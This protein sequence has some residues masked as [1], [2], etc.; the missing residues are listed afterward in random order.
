MWTAGVPK[1]DVSS[2]SGE[3]WR[4]VEDQANIATMRV[5]D[6]LSEQELLER[7]I[8]ATKPALP[9]ACKNFHFLIATP[10]RYAPYP[11]GSRFRRASQADGVF[12]AS[13]LVGTAV[14]ESAF[15]RTLFIAEAPGMPLPQRSVSH[16]AFSVRITTDN[17]I[18][19]TAEPLVADASKWTHPTDYGACQD[20]ADEARRQDIG[21]IRYRSIRSPSAEG[22]NAAILTPAAF[23]DHA[24]R[25]LQT[26]HM[27]MR[28][29]M[30]E[31][32][33]EFPRQTH[34]FIYSDWRKIDGRIPDEIG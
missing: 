1:F 26:W 3:V 11:A 4:L 19:L 20:L 18:D 21:V 29:T 9:E 8:E 30:I 32:W 7:A 25:R 6:T 27:L 28:K 13:D 14:A 17:A 5:V 23:I 16:T 33:C 22:K 31:A 15:Y 24:P 2:F 12:Y 10:F 34:Q